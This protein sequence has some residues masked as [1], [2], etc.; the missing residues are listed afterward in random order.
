MDKPMKEKLVDKVLVFS[1]TELETGGSTI[2]NTM[3]NFGDGEEDFVNFLQQHPEVKAEDLLAAMNVC[4]S[5]GLFKSLVK[6]VGRHSH[7]QLTEE[8]QGRAISVEAAK[9]ATSSPQAS[10]GD[11]HIGTLNASGP[12][13]VGNQ[14]V[15]NIENAL[16]ML[17]QQIDA[18]EASEEEKKSAKALLVGFLKHPLTS[19]VLGAGATGLAAL[20]GGS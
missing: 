12:T 19:A 20:A 1:N 2:S 18:T 3:F 15:Q 17:I 5:R 4:L 6:G 8:G 11:I 9:H 14:N 13:Q 7:L 16:T 10:S